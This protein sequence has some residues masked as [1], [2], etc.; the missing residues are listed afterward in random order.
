M[1]V[2]GDRLT[3]AMKRNRLMQKH[4]AK[5]VGVS[6]IAVWSWQSGQAEA[7]DENFTKLVAFLRKF[8]PGLKASDI[9]NGRA[10]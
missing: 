8:E 9:L 3:R 2:N 4:V 1:K 7:S 6:R 10:A 5:G